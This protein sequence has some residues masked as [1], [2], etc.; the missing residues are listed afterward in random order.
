MKL[1]IHTNDFDN[2]SDRF[3]NPLIIKLLS[4]Y[5]N[6]RKFVVE[7]GTELFVMKQEYD[8]KPILEAKRHGRRI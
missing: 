8:K 2:S 3:T 7:E 1:F 6:N 4:F 5:E